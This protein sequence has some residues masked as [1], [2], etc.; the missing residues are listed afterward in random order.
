MMMKVMSCRASILLFVELQCQIKEYSYLTRY[1]F[2]ITWAVV[3]SVGSSG[4]EGQQSRLSCSKGVGSS[5]RDG[6]AE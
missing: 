5:G 1:P 2:S 4:R 3:E 6:T